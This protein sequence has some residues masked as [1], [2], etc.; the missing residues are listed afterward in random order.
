MQL[1][2]YLLLK[3]RTIKEE[4]ELWQKY[5]CPMPF[6][7]FKE[8]GDRE[9][10]RMLCVFILREYFKEKKNKT[11]SRR[12]VAT[13]LNLSIKATYDYLPVKPVK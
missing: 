7:V 2:S 13:A 1:S 12:L 8:L 4:Y 5:V 9:K 3:K 11:Q 6:D 10:K